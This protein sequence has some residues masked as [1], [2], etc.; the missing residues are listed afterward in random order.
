MKENNHLATALPHPLISRISNL[1]ALGF[2]ED[3]MSLNIIVVKISV[4]A[5]QTPRISAWYIKDRRFP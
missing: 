4:A 1:S 3:H 5:S 2:W